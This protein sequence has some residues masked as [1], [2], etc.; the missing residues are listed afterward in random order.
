MNRIDLWAGCLP[1]G[2]AI[3]T[4]LVAAV[5]GAIALLTFPPAAHAQSLRLSD[6]L[7]P[8]PPAA[9]PASDTVRL[10]ES[11]ERIL[12]E[13]ERTLQIALSKLPTGGV[14]MMPAVAP[15]VAPQVAQEGGSPIVKAC[16]ES[17]VSCGLQLLASA[18][19]GT[20]DAIRALVPIAQPIA[21]IH[22]T[23]AQSA[24]NIKIAEFGRDQNVALYGT[25]GEM[26]A[27][28]AG[29]FAAYAAQAQ[30]LQAQL[31]ANQVPTTA[32]TV[33]GNGPV[34]TGTG[35]IT[36]ASNNPSTTQPPVVVVGTPGTTVSRGP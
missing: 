11:L 33:N 35:T 21:A 26:N 9:A 1:I 17:W 8:A 31:L 5:L 2:R 27:A 12:A 34:N 25:F 19:T 18:G 6:S 14:V 3:E 30:A 7:Q 22:T 32:V 10:V 16:A 4:L 23:R 36:N 29:A 15:A 13:R 24:A 28:N 20:V